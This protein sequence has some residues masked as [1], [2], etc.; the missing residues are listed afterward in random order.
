MP[1]YTKYLFKDGNRIVHGGITKDPERRELEHQQKWPN[2]HMIKVGWS[3]SLKVAREWE[4]EKG[5]TDNP[6]RRRQK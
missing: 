3:K 2:G 4:A 5:F 6:K 1:T